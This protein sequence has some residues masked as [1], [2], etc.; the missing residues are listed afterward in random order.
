MTLEYDL[1]KKTTDEVFVEHELG[2]KQYFSEFHKKK[3]DG[4]DFLTTRDGHRMFDLFYDIVLD[5][6]RESYEKMTKSLE[7]GFPETVVEAFIKHKTEQQIN[8]LV[9]KR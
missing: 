9:Y 7:E 4:L 5:K 1:V 8:T 2:L 3:G 6:N